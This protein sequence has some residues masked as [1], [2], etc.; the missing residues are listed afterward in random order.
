MRRKHL[1]TRVMKKVLSILITVMCFVP[2]LKFEVKALTIDPSDYYYIA[3]ALDTNQVLDVSGGSHR[4]GAN[5]QLYQ[6]NGTDAQLFKIV[7]SSEEG[8]LNI[9]NKGS[10]KAL[11]VEDGRT[12]S[13]S[14]VQLYEHNDTQAQQWQIFL[15][16]D[17]SEN[18]YIISRCEKYLD[19][20]GGNSS[21]GTNI[22]IYDGN[23]TLAQEF[24]LIPYIKTTYE[25]VTLEFSDL[26][27]WKNE[28]EKAQRSVTF[29]GSFVTNPSGNTYYNGK[30]IMDMTV[31]SWKTI[32]VKI[33]LS[34]PGN[35]YKWQEIKLPCEIQFK[36]HE[37]NNETK[38]WYKI[39][40]F[41]FYQQCECGYRDE[42][43][44][45]IPLPDYLTEY[46]DAQTT[47][48]VIKAIQPKHTIL[49]TIQ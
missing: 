2:L 30:I 11:D 16:N 6:K 28:F 26:D 42:W 33:P 21:N 43:N 48:S 4:N 9:I 32:K 39:T 13:K 40:G 18:I 41:N 47:D 38:M 19:A 20:C 3:S 24:V 8:Y 34:G 49:Y 17:S 23:N 15:K 25:T 45:E 5:I 12:E 31:L 29:G 35:P 44:F 14:N 10:E 27:S 22:W 1:V 36:L 37:H 46:T 7:R